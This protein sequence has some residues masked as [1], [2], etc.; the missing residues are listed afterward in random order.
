MPGCGDCFNHA[1]DMLTCITEP[2]FQSQY[3]PFKIG[4]LA[5]ASI[6]QREEE[7]RGQ[8]CSA[9]ISSEACGSDETCE[10]GQAG[11]STEACK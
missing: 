5:C 2:H 4:L 7:A 8:T 6:K 9:C 1:A 11:G 10:P 3:A